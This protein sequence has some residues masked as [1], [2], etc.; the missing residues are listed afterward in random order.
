MSYY[1]EGMS[2]TDYC[3]VSRQISI[4]VGYE[5]GVK[6][7]I[8]PNNSELLW[9][10]N[11]SKAEEETFTSQVTNINSS[12]KT[13]GPARRL[14]GKRIQSSQSSSSCNFHI[15]LESEMATCALCDVVNGH[16]QAAHLLPKKY[17]N[18]ELSVSGV[19]L[20]ESSFHFEWNFFVCSLSLSA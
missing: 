20:V 5:S 3:R 8:Y 16:F 10:E 9:L 12:D 19:P 18:L 1:S 17:D 15:K 13:K 2:L 4:K 11:C 7:Y 14:V 6:L